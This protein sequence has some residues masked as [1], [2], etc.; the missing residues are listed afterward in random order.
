MRKWEVWALATV[1][2]VVAGAL[3]YIEFISEDGSGSPVPLS[4]YSCDSDSDCVST[5][6]AGCVDLRFART[7]DDP[8]VNVRAY[9][10][11]CVGRT[12]YS[13]GRPWK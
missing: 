1:L 13:D 4:P 6:G 12:C 9:D 2:I 10:C 5:C 3:I 7:Y 11:S 8:C